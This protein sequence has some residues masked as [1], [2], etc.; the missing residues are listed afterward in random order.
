MPGSKMTVPDVWSHGRWI[1]ERHAFRKLADLIDADQVTVSAGT[2]GL[3]LGAAAARPGGI[4]ILH[5]YPHGRRQRLLARSYLSRRIPPRT[6]FVAVSEYER[7]ILTSLWRVSKRQSTV[8]TLLSTVG[9]LS[10]NESSP[11]EP[12]IVLTASLLEEYKRPLEWVD[13][14]VEVSR[15]LTREAVR[16]VWLG[17]GSML[18]RARQAARDVADVADIT[19]P[20]V[21][22][23][24]GPAYHSS[25]LYLQLSS[26]ENMSLS[27]LDAQRHGLPCV[28]TSA[29]GLP[30][31]VQD[32]V[33]GRVVPIGETA[34]A[35]DAICELLTDPSTW[36]AYSAGAQR[37]YAQRHSEECWTRELLAIHM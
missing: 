25:R 34:L 20:G 8:E 21:S 33:N 30:E 19:F 14:A 26:I 7:G 15:R 5:T 16:F 36:L 17:E 1:R 28:V 13:V 9:P 32:G 31:I 2:P 18:E 4:Y 29:G 37:T 6:R 27:V 23:D 3:L 10:S 22:D 24:P 12:W 35:A 11:S